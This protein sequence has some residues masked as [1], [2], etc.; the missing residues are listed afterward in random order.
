MMI[1]PLT[2]TYKRRKMVRAW[3]LENFGKVRYKE[4]NI[5]KHWRTEGNR[6]EGLG[7]RLGEDTLG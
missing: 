6:E 7:L 5:G 2:R 1:L 4:R 3:G